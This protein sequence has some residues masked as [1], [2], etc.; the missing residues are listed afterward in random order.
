MDGSWSTE[1][2]ILALKKL[3]GSAT[4]TLS[5]Q[6]VLSTLLSG[7]YS[8]SSGISKVKLSGSG[9]SKS[10]SVKLD[11]ISSEEGKEVEKL[12]GKIL[13]QSVRQ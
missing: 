3:G 10:T 2:N 13:G 4:I 9:A 7:S 8:T 6:R 12:R 5:N 1:M 11:F